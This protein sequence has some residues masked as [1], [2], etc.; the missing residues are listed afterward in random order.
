MSIKQNIDRAKSDY[1]AVKEAGKQE[2]YDLFWDVFQQNG[3]RTSYIGA[4]GACWTAETFRPKY[5]IRPTNA[6]FMFFNNTGEGILIDDFVE[7]SKEHN[8][9]LD[10]SQCTKATYGIGC[11][12][13]PH[14]GVLDFSEC[15]TMDSLFYGHS[16]SNGTQYGVRTIDKFVSSEK[17]VFHTST[18]QHA[19][20]LTNITFEG[21]I[22]TS[23]NFSN[24][25]KLTRASIESVIAHLSTTVS[26]QT[27]TFKTAAVNAAF[28]TD[29]WNALKAT[30]TNWTFS[31]A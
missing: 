5:P 28:T 12:M 18:F 25:S 7:F 27:V 22:A 14:F 29:E 1:D 3:N 13:S 11:L 23:I 17:T 26:G 8:I 20:N 2:Q 31:L 4:F 19:T 6:Y 10:Y 21:V 24:N 15:T 30:R 16:F 9:V